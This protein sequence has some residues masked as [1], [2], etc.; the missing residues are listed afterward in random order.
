M[1]L[2]PFPLCF[3]PQVYDFVFDK[4]RGKWVPWM[5]TIQSKK[6][7]PEAE[8]STIIVNTVS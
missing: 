8:Y 1:N 6:I 4:E 5:D 2:I 3:S 7:A